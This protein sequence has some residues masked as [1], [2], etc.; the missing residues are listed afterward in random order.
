[1]LGICVG[2]QLLADASEESPE[3]RGLGWIGGLVKRLPAAEKPAFRMS[4]GT[5]WNSSVDQGVHPGQRR[6]T[7]L[8][9]GL[10]LPCRQCIAGG[11]RRG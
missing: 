1:M 4:G 11:G 6:R 2:M 7:S 9:C 8:R 5:P 10:A 3:A